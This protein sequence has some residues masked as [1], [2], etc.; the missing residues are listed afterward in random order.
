MKFIIFQLNKFSKNNY[1]ILKKNDYKLTKSNI[2]MW[3]NLTYN[4]YKINI[5]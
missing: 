3:Y 2:D 4:F 1:Y 5:W